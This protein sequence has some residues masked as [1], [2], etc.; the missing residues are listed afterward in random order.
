MRRPFAS[1]IDVDGRSA[2]ALVVSRV[3]TPSAP[4]CVVGIVDG[5]AEQANGHRARFGG[6]MA[7]FFDCS[8]DAVVVLSGDNALV[9]GFSG[10]NQ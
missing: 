5:A 2:E 4:G 1:L 9:A 10:A 8:R 3:G 6:P 7:R